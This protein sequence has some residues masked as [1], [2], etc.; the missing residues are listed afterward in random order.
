MGLTPLGR[1]QAEL[2]GAFLKKEGL[3]WS[4]V[5][6]SP[7]E[8]AAETA[9]IICSFLDMDYSLSPDLREVGNPIRETLPALRKRFRHI[10]PGERLE[11]SAEQRKG[12]KENNDLCGARGKRF[13]MSLLEHGE[14]G[15]VLLV[16]HGHLIFCTVLTMTG[17]RVQPWNCGMAELKVW[18]DGRAKLVKATYPEVLP[19]EAITSNQTFFHKDPWFARF[20]PYPAPRPDAVA[21]MND[22]FRKFA[23]GGKSSWKPVRGT[24]RQYIV[25]GG[26]KLSLTGGK[27][28][29]AVVSPR[30]PLEKGVTYVCRMEFHGKG[31]GFCRI[32]GLPRTLVKLSPAPETKTCELKFGTED[33]PKFVLFHL[34][35]LPG[36]ELVL[37]G[38]RLVRK[39][40]VDA[41]GKVK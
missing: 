30:F 26:G 3:R 32:N 22:E 5:I 16:A 40:P 19:A 34:E 33:S 41:S 25:T 1:K 18:P 31:T 28:S 10:A 9:E 39:N 35:A 36:S 6:S 20:I 29:S 17:E 23:D 11:L 7:Q 13:I 37:T 14:K 21:L 8:R 2:T 38:F 12:F 15:P 4:R 24:A 27:K